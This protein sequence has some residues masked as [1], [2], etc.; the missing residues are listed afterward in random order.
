MSIPTSQE[1]I[2]N[3]LRLKGLKN[4]AGR[5]RR[6]AGQLPEFME[7][8]IPDYNFER[9][10]GNANMPL[11]DL[12]G[13]GVA[14]ES[15]DV[16]ANQVVV[17]PQ[18]GETQEEPGMWTK[19]G[20]NIAKYVENQQQQ[21]P[22]WQS[23]EGGV[24]N[25]VKNY[26][27]NKQ[28]EQSQQPEMQPIQPEMNYPK[29][30]AYKDAKWFE[31]NPPEFDPNA[32]EPQEPGV[33]S[34]IGKYL[35][36][37]FEGL[38]KGISPQMEARNP[39]MFKNYPEVIARKEEEAKIKEQEQA[40]AKIDSEKALEN[41]YTTVVYGSSNKVANQPE[42]QAQFKDITGIDYNEEISKKLPEYEKVLADMQDNLNGEMNGYSEQ[43]TRLR[44][45]I[46][47]NQVTN[48]DKL[49]IGMALMMPLL[50][51]GFF[52]K[53]AALGALGGGAQ[54]VA[55]ILQRK[56][57]ENLDTEELLANIGS[58]KAENKMKQAELQFKTL[59]IPETIR[60]GLPDDMK[61]FLKGKKEVVWN[62][63]N[64]GKEKK[65]ILIKPGLVA[66]PEYVANKEELKDMRD[67][68]NDISDALTAVKE[69]NYLTDD[70][71]DI[72]SKMKDKTFLGKGL[73]AFLTGQ[74]PSLASKNADMIDYQGRKVNAYIVLEH[75]IKLL[76]DAYRQAKGMRALTQSVQ[77]H[78]EG[79]FRNPEGSFQSHKDTVDQMLYTR[80]LALD[81]LGNNAKDKGFAPE[82]LYQELKPKVQQTF[83]KLNYKEGE[84]ESDKLLGK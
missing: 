63:P 54:G 44:D 48:Q 72:S 51:G 52:G 38:G 40:Q 18:E 74:S 58:K 67:S 62:D 71:I 64:D 59:S 36:S 21:P 66:M 69:V 60:K 76:T 39:E 81:R 23:Q 79:L 83:N 29:S 27:E 61:E 28:P 84:K 24:L 9:A 17:P 82:F 26:V 70:I 10:G 22:E 2:G 12:N 68:A 56:S 53:E 73:A 20:R 25:K 32:L 50:V 3:L 11:P 6:V 13:G 14:P 1:G 31:N 34:K 46:L 35:S 65:G 42:L 4:V 41:P 16:R 30:G 5:G 80:D 43:E 77:D 49:F 57:K 15:Y 55:D 37:D 19:L 45:K 75:K 33:L 8:E 47:S 78:I 7:Q